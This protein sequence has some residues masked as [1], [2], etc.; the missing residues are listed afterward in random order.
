MSVEG[1]ILLMVITMY[2]AV[3][4]ACHKINLKLLAGLVVVGVGVGIGI[5]GGRNA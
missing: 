5:G 2:H 1:T 4:E 3:I